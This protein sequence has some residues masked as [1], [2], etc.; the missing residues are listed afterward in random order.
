L[1][2]KIVIKTR[3]GAARRHWPLAWDL[4]CNTGT[5]S[6]LV[7]PHADTVVALDADHLAVERLYRELR[8]GDP[9]AA[10]ILPLVG[11][12]VDPSPALGWRLGERR[13]LT[14]RPAPDLILALAL[15]HHVVLTGNVPLVEFLDWLAR[16]GGELILEWVD[17]EDAMVKHLL[18]N[19]EDIYHDYTA[20]A[21]N[22]H[23]ENRFEVLERRSLHRG[24]R[25]L[26][27][28]R[29]R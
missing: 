6:R 21:F 16:L 5:F 8:R 2:I 17:R 23:L 13:A 24:T 20:E 3:A 12:L 19:K 29:P 27:H 7:A 1:R 22:A 28:A 18:R 4:G 10:K 25:T 14:G 26:V 11:N 15:I 9:A